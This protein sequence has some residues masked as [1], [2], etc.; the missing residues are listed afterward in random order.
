MR[1]APL[2]IVALLSSSA[3]AERPSIAL[4]G[5]V[6]TLYEHSQTGLVIPLQVR[7]DTDERF[8][9][10][11]GRDTTCT[12]DALCA[13]FGVYRAGAMVFARHDALAP[14]AY[15]RLLYFVSGAES[16]EPHMYNVGWHYGA[17]GGV[18][19]TPG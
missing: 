7:I 9:I 18:E 5:G 1:L 17:G 10:E 11:F 8:A 13:L 4:S 2:V 16:A 12:G 15:G 14:Y 6:G 19:W 3:A